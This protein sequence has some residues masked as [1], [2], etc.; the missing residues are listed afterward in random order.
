MPRKEMHK[1]FHCGAAIYRDEGA[2]VW[3]SLSKPKLRCVKSPTGQHE[4]VR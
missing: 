3:V 2:P 1:C 4:P